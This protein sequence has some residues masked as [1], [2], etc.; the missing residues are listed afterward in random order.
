MMIGKSN[1]TYLMSQVFFPNY[2]LKG[3]N[4]FRI[5]FTIAMYIYS[6]YAITFIPF[7][8]KITLNLALTCG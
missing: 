6:N 1:E 3:N 8:L 4:L 2:T 7:T 5:K